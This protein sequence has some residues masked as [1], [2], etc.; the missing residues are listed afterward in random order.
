MMDKKE[1]HKV[2]KIISGADG[3][4]PWC[5]KNLLDFFVHEF[6]EHKDVANIYYKK[7]DKLFKEHE[8]LGYK[9]DE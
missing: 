1:V 9:N 5:V 6:P 8:K 7:N 3:G 4:C 2:L